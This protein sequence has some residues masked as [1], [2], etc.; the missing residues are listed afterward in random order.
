MGVFEQTWIN[1]RYKLFFLLFSFFRLFGTFAVLKVYSDCL[2]VHTFSLVAVLH[3][4]F[5]PPFYFLFLSSLCVAPHQRSSE[6]PFVSDFAPKAVVLQGRLIITEYTTSGKTISTSLMSNIRETKITKKK[7]WRG[8][9]LKDGRQLLC[10][11]QLSFNFLSWSCH[12]LSL[13]WIF[14]IKKISV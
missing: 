3:I 5:F 12:F 7:G 10:E 8:K 13:W 1:R 14:W 4:F 2:K 11:N 6:G 9:V